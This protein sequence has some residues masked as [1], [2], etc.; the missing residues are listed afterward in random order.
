MKHKQPIE[1][2]VIQRSAEI[3]VTSLFWLAWLYLV[4]PLLSL[5]LWIAGIELFADEMIDRGGMQALIEELIQ[6]GT[7][8]LGMFFLTLVWISWN[9]HHYGKHNKRTHSPVPVRYEELAMYSGLS[10][11]RIEEIQKSKRI[12]LTFDDT[13]HPII[14]KLDSMGVPSGSE[15]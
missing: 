13:D 12:S 5:L 9:L 6:Y 4:M 14:H 15:H 7:I 11:S 8:V 2:G 10:V 1:E 3:T